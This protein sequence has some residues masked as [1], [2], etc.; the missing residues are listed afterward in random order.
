MLA[1]HGLHDRD[2][3]REPDVGELRRVDHVAGGE[4]AGDA[5]L[6]LLVDHDVAAIV[7]ADA[8]GFEP[9]STRERRA[10][11]R[12]DHLVDDDRLR[13]TVGLPRNRELACAVD[14][15]DARAL[16]PR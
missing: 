1:E 16:R 4:D 9:D 14:T 11:D 2:P 15:G 7:D 6:Q 12:H 5:R 13:P 10:A 3:F 8:G